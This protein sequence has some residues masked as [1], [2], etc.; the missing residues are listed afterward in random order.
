MMGDVIDVERGFVFGD[1]VLPRGG[2]YGPLDRAYVTFL[3]IRSGAARVE[4]DDRT[5]SVVAGECAVVVNRR[6]LRIF[7]QRHLRTE[8]SWCEAHPA[9]LAAGAQAP[10][11]PKLPFC[12]RLERLQAMGLE[13]GLGSGPS[14]NVLRNALGRALFAGYAHESRASEAERAVPPSVLRARRCIEE[15]F[16]EDLVLADIASAAALSP[17]HLVS[18]FRR[19]LGTTPIRHL[20]RV[21]AREAHQLLLASD[22]PSA[23]VAYRCGYKSPFHFSRQ[24]KAVFGEAPSALRRARGYRVPSN[25][26]EDARDVLY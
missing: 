4:V 14:L 3:A 1:V 7:Y 13:L 9:T 17:A 16:A 22:L 10:F 6:R 8:A 24:I 19:H 15:R 23:E 11:A 5:L 12:G 18:V 20:W 21:R 26:A 25:V 2:E